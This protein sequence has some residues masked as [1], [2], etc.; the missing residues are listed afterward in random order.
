[1]LAVTLFLIP[2]LYIIFMIFFLNSDKL[3]VLHGL[4]G[5]APRM[6][7]EKFHSGWRGLVGL[8]SVLFRSCLGPVLVLLGSCVRH[9]AVM[10]WSDVSVLC[11]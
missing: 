10:S 9:G 5:R 1:M 4:G 6:R 3:G 8:V 7:Q 2:L 11:R